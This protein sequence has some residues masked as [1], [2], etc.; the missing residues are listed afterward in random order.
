MPIRDTIKNLTD[1]QL[2]ELT[3][4][5]AQINRRAPHNPANKQDF[6]NELCDEV[7]SR[8]GS[9]RATVEAFFTDELTPAAAILAVAPVALAVWDK[10]GIWG[11][12]GIQRTFSNNDQTVAGLGG[13][14]TSRS[15]AAVT[16]GKYYAEVRVD[17]FVAASNGINVGLMSAL[18]SDTDHDIGWETDGIGIALGAAANYYVT[19]SGNTGP[20]GGADEDGDVIMI[21]YDADNDLVYFGVNGSWI[22]G[23]P[24]AGTGGLDYSAQSANAQH[25]AVKLDGSRQYSLTAN[26]SLPEGYALWPAA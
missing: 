16:S 11:N 6:L 22:I 26:Y 18:S 4:E 25:L 8:H 13:N 9:D 19:G 14:F 15:V 20:G 23:D 10:T 17:T 3:W 21:A 24:V 7:A 5:A 2:E 1:A 12:E